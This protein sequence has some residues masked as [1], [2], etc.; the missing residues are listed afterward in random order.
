MLL[1]DNR[2]TRPPFKRALCVLTEQIWDRQRPFYALAVDIHPFYIVLHQKNG[3]NKDKQFK[4][5]HNV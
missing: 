4:F 5:K 1:F 3:R 2:K